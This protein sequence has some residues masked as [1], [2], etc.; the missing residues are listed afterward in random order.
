MT[1]ANASKQDRSIVGTIILIALAVLA[2]VGVVT[3][4]YRLIN[5]LGGHFSSHTALIVGRDC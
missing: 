5:G 3:G 2:L 4:V 1:T